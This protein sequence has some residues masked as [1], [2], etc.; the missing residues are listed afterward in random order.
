MNPF[1]ARFVSGTVIPG[2][3][4]GFSA[5]RRDSIDFEVAPRLVSKQG[6]FHSRAPNFPLPLPLPLEVHS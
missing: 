1:V 5:S 2:C 6:L 3:P 4:L